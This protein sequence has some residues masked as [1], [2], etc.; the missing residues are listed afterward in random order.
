MKSATIK[1]PLEP[2]HILP[3]WE[4]AIT[5]VY[6]T[7]KRPYT[8][9]CAYLEEARSTHDPN[10]LWKHVA[11]IDPRR[12]IEYYINNPKERTEILARLVDLPAIPV[13]GCKFV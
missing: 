8:Y 6:R 11:T 2:A 1:L 10:K 3:N 5:L 7:R 9:K 12:W 4:A 13:K